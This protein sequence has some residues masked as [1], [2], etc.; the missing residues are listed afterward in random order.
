MIF[1]TQDS[2]EKY[3]SCCSCCC[4]SCLAS[5]SSS[6]TSYDLTD[7]LSLSLLLLHPP[8]QLTNRPLVTHLQH[9]VV[10]SSLASCIASHPPSAWLL[11]LGLSSFLFSFSFATT[12]PCNFL[13]LVRAHLQHASGIITPCHLLLLLHPI[14][15]SAC[16]T[17]SFAH[18]SCFLLLAF[19]CC[20]C[21]L[22]IIISHHQNYQHQQ[23]PAPSTTAASSLQTELLAT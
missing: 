20:C 16:I 22:T 3:S 10:H 11:L 15:S 4:C 19:C 1:R 2:Q 12:H 21:S 7:L 8:H 18:S 17:Q 6:D 23:A 14:S 9:I 5:C 13:L